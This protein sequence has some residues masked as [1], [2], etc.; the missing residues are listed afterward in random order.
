ME[1][2]LMIILGLL[3]LLGGFLMMHKGAKA[4]RSLIKEPAASSNKLNNMTKVC[5]PKITAIYPDFTLEE[6]AIQAEDALLS[7]FGAITAQNTTLLHKCDE[8]LHKQV[9]HIITKLQ[10]EALASVFDEVS[11]EGTVIANCR[12]ENSGYLITFQCAVYCYNYRLKE[13][14]LS[15]GSTSEKIHAKYNITLDTQHWLFTHFEHIN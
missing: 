10:K 12:Q 14:L 3:M 1:Q 11:F 7:V 15:S 8:K 4:A 9:S 2:L 13:G 6:Y 5:L